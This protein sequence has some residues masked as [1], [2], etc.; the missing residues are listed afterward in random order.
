V[1]AIIEENVIQSNMASFNDTV[2]D[3]QYGDD[4]FSSLLKGTEPDFNSIYST[5]L[6][7]A[8]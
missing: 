4:I 1:K 7:Q 8:N 5:S 2:A 3:L 6:F